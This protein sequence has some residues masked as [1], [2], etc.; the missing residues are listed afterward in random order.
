MSGSGTIDSHLLGRMGGR[1]AREVADQTRALET[2]CD[3]PEGRFQWLCDPVTQVIRVGILAEL[4]RI[5][6][7]DAMCAIAARICELKPRTGEAV[8]MIRRWRCD[9]AARGDTDA[10]ALDILL[11]IDAYSVRHPA[12]SWRQVLKALRR[13]VRAA[14]QVP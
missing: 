2:L 3:D 5:G 12:T 11:A 10:L 1:R 14:R 6:D 4:G 13:L 7:P 8:A 9:L